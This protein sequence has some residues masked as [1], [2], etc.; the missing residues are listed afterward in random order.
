MEVPYRQGGTWDALR[1]RPC[2]HVA[3][4]V[5]GLF[6]FLGES[7]IEPPRIWLLVPL[8]CQA[9]QAINRAQQVITQESKAPHNI[10]YGG[11]K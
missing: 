4:G 3:L 6:F 11:Y 10:V 5:H 9:T 8:Q 1:L 7:S 2:S